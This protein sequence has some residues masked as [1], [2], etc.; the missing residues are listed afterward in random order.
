V[1]ATAVVSSLLAS[2]PPSQALT[3]KGSAVA[4]NLR[5]MAQVMPARYLYRSR[6]LFEL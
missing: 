3:K 6:F 5:K 1:E 2:L 4:T